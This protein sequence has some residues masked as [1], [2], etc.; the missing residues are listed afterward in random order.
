MEGRILDIVVCGA[1]KPFVRGGA[2]QHQENLAAALT[3]AGHRAEIVRLPVAWERGRL[4]DAPL[5]WR[6]VDLDA[7]LV[8]ATN[9]PSYFVRHPNKVVW[10]LH[11]HRGAYDGFATGADWSDFGLDDV[12]LEEQR[13]MT[14]WDIVALSDA[15]KVFSNSRVVSERLARY[16]GLDSTPLAHPPP[17]SDRLHPGPFGDYVLSV[18]RQEANKRPQL[19][20]DAMSNVPAPLRAVMAGRGELLPR[21]EHRVSELDLTGRVELPGFVL[22]DAVVDLF[23]GALAV[24]YVPEDEDYGYATLQA[25]YAGKPVICAADSGAV[26]DWVEDGVTGLVTDGTA[27][28]LAAAIRRLHQDRDLARRLGA[29][30]RERVASLSWADVVARLTAR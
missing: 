19:L 17:L 20:V 2:E 23:A 3:G 4:F 29:A 8:I 11:Q 13:L 7:D 24:V 25:F 15:Q 28:G 16:N 1:Q 21:L 12:S 27:S 5:A 18:Q 26:L 10:L 6:M 22:D 14:E 30:G 9:F